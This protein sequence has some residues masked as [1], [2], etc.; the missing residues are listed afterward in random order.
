MS[1]IALYACGGLGF[2]VGARFARHI[3][4]PAQGFAV[5]DPRFI[6]TSDANLTDAIPKDR[7]WIPST[8]KGSGKSR[9]QN[10][11]MIVSKAKEI[12]AKFPPTE[13]NVFVHSGHGGS[14]SVIGPVLAGELLSRG[15]KV[16]VLCVGGTASRKET[17]NN[18]DTL[19]SYENLAKL[20]KMP[21]LMSYSENSKDLP[22]AKVDA[23]LN[24]IIVLLAA[25]FSG[26]NKALDDT[27][28]AN[29]LNFPK[30]TTFKPHLTQ[31]DFFCKEVDLPDSQAL[32]AAVTLAEEGTDTDIN[33]PVEYQAVGFV[34]EN[35]KEGL[36]TEMPVHVC[37]IAGFH[38]IVMG[39]LNAKIKEYEAVREGVVQESITD[40]DEDSTSEGIILN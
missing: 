1:K 24:N 20:Y 37:A 36:K 6:D 21:V 38:N 5:V 8:T 13:V 22:P 27:D 25:V 26:E 15:H 31:L 2:N 29:F 19:K 9:K 18:R 11:D 30:V 33:V 12:L 17:E 34:G 40:D 28:L 16:I 23:H 14:G 35:V 32:V 10:Y 4:D 39:R 3:D 7:V